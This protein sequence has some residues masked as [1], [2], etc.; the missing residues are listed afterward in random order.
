MLFKEID[1]TTLVKGKKYFVK[2]RCQDYTIDRC[3][4]FKRYVEEDIAYFTNITYNNGQFQNIY[5]CS[6]DI[7][8][9]IVIQ[10]EIRQLAMEQR[11]IH[12]ILRQI[13][14]DETFKYILDK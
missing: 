1:F 3:G 10:K 4:Y 5:L 7:F 6:R 9:D 12:M 14:G 11:A 8:F 2:I 13:T